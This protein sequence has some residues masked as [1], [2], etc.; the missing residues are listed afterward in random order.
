M[1]RVTVLAACLLAGCSSHSNVIESYFCAKDN[2]PAA[3]QIVNGILY[4]S[5]GTV[6]KPIASTD[7]VYIYQV[8]KGK[9]AFE[10]P[11]DDIADVYLESDSGE[12]TITCYYIKTEN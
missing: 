10:I 11:D 3:F 9:A 7:S 8:G 1:M 2:K 6:H 4:H 12:F 5:D